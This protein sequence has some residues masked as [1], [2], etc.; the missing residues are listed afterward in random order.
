M[1]KKEKATMQNADIRE[2]AK[3]VREAEAKLMQLSV[4]RHTKQ[5]KNV[6]EV[7]TLRH[8][9]AVAKTILRE[10]ELQHE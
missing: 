3:I 10:K 9:I 1:K 2:L 5:T 4:T 7:R 8:E 6:R